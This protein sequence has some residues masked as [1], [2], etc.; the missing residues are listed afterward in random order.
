LQNENKKDEE[1]SVGIHWK[2]DDMSEQVDF[3]SLDCMVDF[4]INL[5]YNKK[6]IISITLPYIWDVDELQH[7]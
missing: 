2:S 5:P 3:C 1:F 6:E 4:L 7:S